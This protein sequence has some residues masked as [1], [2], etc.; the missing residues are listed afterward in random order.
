VVVFKAMENKRTA[1]E[2][3]IFLAHPSREGPHLGPL[4]IRGKQGPRFCYL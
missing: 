2:H 4:Q 3:I 1:K